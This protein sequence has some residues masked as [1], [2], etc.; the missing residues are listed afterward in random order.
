MCRRRRLHARPS[1][2]GLKDRAREARH[3]AIAAYA[4]EMAGTALDLDHDLEAAG[5]EPWPTA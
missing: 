5:V 2:R 3:D 1:I 4:V